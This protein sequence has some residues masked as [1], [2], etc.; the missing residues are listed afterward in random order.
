MKVHHIIWIACGYL[1]V[2][3]MLFGIVVWWIVLRELFEGDYEL[4]ENAF[5][6]IRKI[7]KKIG[8]FLNKNI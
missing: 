8:T 4:D 1:W 5:P 3:G 7:L 2:F 6:I